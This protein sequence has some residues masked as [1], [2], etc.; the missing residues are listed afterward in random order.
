M[1]VT[2]KN[3][4]N[5]T[6]FKVPLTVAK[7]YTSIGFEIVS[8]GVLEHNTSDATVKENIVVGVNQD[9][10]KKSFARRME[11]IPIASWSKEQIKRYAQI[12]QVDISESKTVGEA[13]GLVKAYIESQK[14]KQEQEQLQEESQES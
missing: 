4:S 10:E 12:Q 7:S 11:N 1:Y 13:R 9:D 14:A 2:M 3:K 6:L 5:N 8:N